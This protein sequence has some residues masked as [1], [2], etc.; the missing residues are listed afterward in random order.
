MVL[1]GPVKP[2]ATLAVTCTGDVRMALLSGVVMVTPPEPVREA[3]RSFGEGA[4]L[5]E[6]MMATAPMARRR[7]MARTIY[8][9]KPRWAR[10]VGETVIEIPTN[11]PP[12]SLGRR[13]G[14]TWAFFKG[15][16]DK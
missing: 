9:M 10:G 14:S 16:S 12:A 15:K 7:T 2:E 1:T 4:G 8:W 3:V 11:M 5:W 13:Q 6:W